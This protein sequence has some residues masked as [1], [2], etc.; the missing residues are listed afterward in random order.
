MLTDPVTRKKFNYINFMV[1]LALTEQSAN[2]T[3]SRHV[4]YAAPLI[5]KFI[6]EIYREFFAVNFLFHVVAKLANYH[7]PHSAPNVQPDQNYYP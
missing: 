6:L 4:T 3:V 2:L 7:G 1:R 5:W